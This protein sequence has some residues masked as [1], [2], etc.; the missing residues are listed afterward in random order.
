MPHR[1]R[2]SDVRRT[3]LVRSAVAITLIALL[4]GLLAWVLHPVCVPLSAEDLRGFNVPIERR[5]DRDLSVPVFQQRH[6]QWYQCKTW[7]SRQF[8]F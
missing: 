3:L 5:T 7:V 8:F 4:A 6:G 2:T 1:S